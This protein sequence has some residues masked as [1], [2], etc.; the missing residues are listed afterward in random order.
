VTHVYA[1]PEQEVLPKL[2]FST[3]IL[4]QT[5]L[6][7]RAPTTTPPTQCAFM[8]VSVSVFTPSIALGSNGRGLKLHQHWGVHELD[9]GLQPQQANICMI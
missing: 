6:L 8:M 2:W 4:V 5:Q 7:G 1:L 9:T 3:L